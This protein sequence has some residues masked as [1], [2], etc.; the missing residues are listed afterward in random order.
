[1][2]NYIRKDNEKYKN[3]VM[4]KQIFKVFFL[5]LKNILGVRLIFF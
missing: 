1:M 2:I 3:N 4:K 5:R